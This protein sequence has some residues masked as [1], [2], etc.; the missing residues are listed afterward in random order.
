MLK[1]VS[2]AGSASTACSTTGRG[3][4]G[5]SGTGWGSMDVSMSVI[6]SPPGGVAVTKEDGHRVHGQEDG[7]QHDAGR[8]RRLGESGLGPARPVEDE[9]GQGRELVVEA[10]GDR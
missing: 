7:E 8:R 9:Q 10:L 3:M 1:T 5:G 6:V 2:R 4:R